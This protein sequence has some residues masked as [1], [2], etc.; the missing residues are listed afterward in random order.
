MRQPTF[1]PCDSKMGAPCPEGI[2][3]WSK[4][5]DQHASTSQKDARELDSKCFRNYV[6]PCTQGVPRWNKGLD[7]QASTSHERHETG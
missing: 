7:R 1:F 3:R 2:T 6:K 4:G 5:F